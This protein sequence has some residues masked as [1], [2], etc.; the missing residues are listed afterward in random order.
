MPTRRL[1]FP[2]F[3]LLV[4]TL[5][6]LCPLAATAQDA[7]DA[8]ASSATPA[9]ADL[10]QLSSRAQQQIR[11]LI[12][13]KQ[14]RTAA[15]RKVGSSLLYAAKARR[16][17]AITATVKTLKPI[18]PERTDGRVDVEIRGSVSKGLVAA[19]EKAGGE[20]LAGRPNGAL[21]RALVPL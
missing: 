16:G 14:A 3:P 5:L 15:Q 2:A 13:D 11:E 18:F 7:N 20:I 12:A 19:I 8:A 6:A 1:V 10:A 9:L 17:Q 21:V 4:I